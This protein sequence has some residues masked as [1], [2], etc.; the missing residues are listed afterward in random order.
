MQ[1]RQPDSSLPERSETLTYEAWKNDFLKV[2]LRI[3]SVLFVIVIAFAFSSNTLTTNILYIILTAIV[4]VVAFAKVSYNVRA[5]VLIVTMF[6]AA[7]ILLVNWG[8]EGEATMLY[9]AAIV[10][11]TLL[12]EKK[13]E[14]IVLGLTTISI[15]SAASLTLSGQLALSGWVALGDEFH[16]IMVADWTAWIVYLLD[17]LAVGGIL[18]FAIRLLKNKF[19]SILQEARISLSELSA[20]RSELEQRVQQRTADLAARTTESER[21]A[22]QMETVSKVARVVVSIQEL[23]RLLPSITQVVSEQFGYYHVGIFL[24][25]E[26]A[27]YAVLQAA[28]S[29]GGQRMLQRGHRLRMGA[30]GIVGH[31]AAQ[32]EPRVALN[33]GADAVF[34]NNPDLPNTRSEAALPLKIGSQTIGVLDVQ[35]TETDAF[36]PE[37]IAIL[38]TLANQIAVAI[39]NARL[40]GQTRRALSESQTIYEEYVKQDWARFARRVETKGFHYDGIKTAPIVEPPFVQDAQTIRVP[41]RIRGLVI[42]HIVLRANDPLR[43]WT[44]DELNLVQAAADRA[45]LAIENVRL[46]GEAQ[47]RAAKERAI[48]EIA[49]RIGASI[50]MDSILQTAVE[51]L[52][53]ALTGSEIILQFQKKD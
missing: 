17:V 35:S 20:G 48:G 2:V 13:F 27:D 53:R 15:L 43:R 37:D 52:G 38:G 39:E 47:R 41:V 10:L 30:I 34:F 44:Q 26:Q 49:S 31:V 14:F 5:V 45:G 25:N 29:E 1:N 7:A 33:V 28:N 18:V 22:R 11:T 6:I 16:A 4:A 40:F 23:D 19:N 46:L 9:L 21:R 51:E 36:Q 42:G 32:G 3:A 50:D 12:F 24:I 8:V